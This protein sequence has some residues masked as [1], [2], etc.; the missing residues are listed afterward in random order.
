[1]ARI[2]AEE[3]RAAGSA[4]PADVVQLG[5][6]QAAQLCR[7][8]GVELVQVEADDFG[9]AQPGAEYEV[10]DCPVAQRPGVPVHCGRLVAAPVAAAIQLVEG[11]DSVQHVLYRPYLRPGKG[12]DLRSRK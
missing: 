6:L 2:A 1:M 12:A 11:L 4:L 3:D 8:G 10:H 5:F 7:R 9:A